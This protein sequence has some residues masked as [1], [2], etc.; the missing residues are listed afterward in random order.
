VSPA[1]FNLYMDN[2][3]K[4][5]G[6]WKTGCVIGNTLLNHLMYTDD[7]VVMSPSTV[8]FQQLLD[9]GFKYGGQFDVQ[10]NARKSVVLVCRT[11]E[12]QKQHFP[13]FHLSGQCICVSNCAKYLGH[14]ITDKMEDDA[15]RNR[16]RRM[17]YVQANM[18]LLKKP[19][20]SSASKLFCDLRVSCLQALLRNPIV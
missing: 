17:L 11:K 4:Q 3:S 7:L 20:S 8:G 10:Y 5:L 19:R 6:I 2:L 13:M 12:D 9:I 14:I 16:Q 18:L 15:D 1:L